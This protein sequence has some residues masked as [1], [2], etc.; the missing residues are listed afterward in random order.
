MLSAALRYKLQLTAALTRYFPRTS[1][2]LR[3]EGQAALL[4]GK[5]RPPAVVNNDPASK[6][7]A[8]KQSAKPRAKSSKPGNAKSAAIYGPALM[9]VDATQIAAMRLRV[10][11]A[12]AAGIVSAPS[13]EQWAMIL[14]R[15]PLTRV[16]AAA[17]SGKSSTLL[18]RLVFMLCHLR[19]D[20]QQLTVISFTNASCAQLREQLLK[21]LRF[22]Q[23]PFDAAQARQSVRTFHSAMG[24][25]AKEALHSPRWFEQL[26]S[27]SANSEL[28]NPLSNS[29]LGPAQL[30]LLKQ[31]YQQCYAEHP[32]FRQLVHG[33]LGLSA[34]APV[35]GNASGKAPLDGYLLAGEF[36][37]APLFA[38]F[39]Q[40]AG[41]IHSIGLRIE[42]L[43]ARTLLCA[44]PERNFIEA[45]VLFWPCFTQLLHTQGLQTF[46]GAFAQLTDRLNAGNSGLSAAALAPFSHL[47]IDEFQDISPQIVLWLNAVQ[48]TLAGQ[49]TAVS[50]MA[51]GDDWQSIY[52]WRGSSPELFINFDQ[53]FAGS[54][55][56]RCSALLQLQNNYRSIEPIIRDGE[57]LLSAVRHKHS[58]T[59]HAMRATRA[60]E[61]GVKLISQFDLKLRLP[62]LLSQIQAQCAQVAAS[63]ADE[64]TGVLVMSRRNAPL[65]L[66][67]AQLDKKL[68]VK[69][70]TIHSAKGLQA[71]V[72]IILDDCPPP[73]AHPLRDAFYAHSGF[74]P[75]SYAQA[76]QDESL[77]LAYVAITRGVSRVFWYCNTPQGATQ[78]LQQRGR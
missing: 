29:R 27:N 72:A 39:Y 53:H 62:E 42:H 50:L 22:W 70:C 49:G 73:P 35:P 8:T 23:Y 30:A 36:T 11:Q 32:E 5:S 16:F 2:Y 66:L 75:N 69:L 34:P 9:A 68:P 10:S 41:F 46:D 40:Q 33:L 58:K 25:L 78:M 4:H 60:G 77:R 45:L 55:K 63:D 13:D 28:D 44:A 18:L 56:A 1:A 7:R 71:Q 76:M 20:P 67:R 59:S 19:I 15:N 24:V 52:G 51:I 37:P 47:L 31:A 3:A 43:Q 61:H 21:I 38:V 74:F 26:A 64:R 65:Q 12:V 6:A 14:E 57:A 54:G 48:R 17:G